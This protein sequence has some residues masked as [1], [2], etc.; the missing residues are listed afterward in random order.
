[1]PA[2]RTGWRNER[3][4]VYYATADAHGVCFAIDRGAS[5]VLGACT[6]C[7]NVNGLSFAPPR[8]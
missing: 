2:D 6:A 4:N 5:L 3:T 1:M 7:A 8:R